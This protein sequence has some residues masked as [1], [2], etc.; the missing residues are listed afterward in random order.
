MPHLLRLL[1]LLLGSA[2]AISLGVLWWLHPDS[3]LPALV[4]LLVLVP[5]IIILLRQQ[6]LAPLPPPAN[7]QGD[8][9]E[10]EPPP[11]LP[12]RGTRP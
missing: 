8:D 5:L 4:L 11:T 2:L 6:P 9:D 1:V 3:P 10:D 12:F 7:G